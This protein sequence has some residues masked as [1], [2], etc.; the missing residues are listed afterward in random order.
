MLLF[1]LLIQSYSL[2]TNTQTYTHT[3]THTHTHKHMELLIK[4]YSDSVVFTKRCYLLD[5]RCN[6]CQRKVGMCLYK[7]CRLN[8]WHIYFSPIGRCR[9]KETQ[10]SNAIR[11]TY[12]LR[13]VFMIA[14]RD[15][16]SLKLIRFEKINTY[17]SIL[18]Q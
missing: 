12:E 4:I 10:T 7:K 17:I 6:E 16:I 9:K 3:H 8:I 18:H 1:S 14:Y 13:L 5:F 15:L 2:F 11:R